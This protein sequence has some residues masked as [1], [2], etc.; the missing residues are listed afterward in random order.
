MLA[1]HSPTSIASSALTI[2]RPASSTTIA[3]PSDISAKYSGELKASAKLRER[4]RDQHQ[5]EHADR[6]G[7]ERGDRGDAER[8]ARAAL[9]RHLVAV[10]AGDDRGR[11]AGHVEQDRGGRA[12]VLG[13]VVDA[14]EH[15][16]RARRV[17]AGR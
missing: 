16:D 3:R 1:I 4:R 13:A 17:H 12:A 5:A 9:A 2:E 6:A 15:D 8:R 11:L 10:D 14:G 7:D